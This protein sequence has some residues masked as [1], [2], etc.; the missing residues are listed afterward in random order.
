M[1]FAAL[2]LALL[3]AG[4]TSIVGSREER[5]VGVVLGLAGGTPAIEV[6]TTVQV[7]QDFTV[8]IRTGWRNG[9]ARQDGTEVRVQ[10]ASA[11]ITP[12]DRIT[13]G[14]VCTQATQEFVH[15]ATLRFAQPGT[16]R[17]LIR[18]RATPNEGARTI[19][20]SVTVR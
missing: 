17:L 1:R 7:G 13:E 10:G 11:T 12:Y 2:G 6:P 14:A 3:A 15:S 4:C 8:T 5:E 19:E 16:A 20:R 9:C 18:G